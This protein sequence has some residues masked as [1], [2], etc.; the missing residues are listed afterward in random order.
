MRILSIMVF[1]LLSWQGALSQEAPPPGASSAASPL[2]ARW[3]S[4][5][6]WHFN[7]LPS[8]NINRGSSNSELS[9]ALGSFQIA[10]YSQGQPG[11]SAL[12]GGSGFTRYR[13]QENSQIIL[14]WGLS[15]RVYE[16]L[17]ASTFT[18]NLALKYQMQ[19]GRNFWELGPSFS[20]LQTQSNATADTTGWSGQFKRG[21]SQSDQVSM[22]LRHRDETFSTASY[23]DG[24]TDTLGLGWVHV[25][26][27]GGA[28]RF[29]VTG[30]V[31]RPQAAHQQYEALALG[32]NYAFQVRNRWNINVGSTVGARDFVGIYPLQLNPRA[33]QFIDFNVKLQN[34]NF[35]IWGAVPTFG[36]LYTYNISNIGL[37]DFKALDC[38]FSF[39]LA[40]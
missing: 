4:G 36:C 17:G 3:Q 26:K 12:L 30:T 10:S 28:T 38:N 25:F 24:T 27:R 21:L 29:E 20:R 18:G 15:T 34:Q 19:T 16:D 40:S 39:A 37:F 31:G 23:L 2:P 7:F 8:S 6:D 13:G 14:N 9:T 5:F 22:Q 11:V 1:C 35:S 32:L 33:D